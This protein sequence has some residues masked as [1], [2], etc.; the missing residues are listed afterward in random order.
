MLL[1]ILFSDVT[2]RIQP[3]QGKDHRTQYK[4]Q[5]PE[6]FG[7]G[8]LWCRLAYQVDKAGEGAAILLL[9]IAAQVPLCLGISQSF[10]NT[11]RLCFSPG[12]SSTVRAMVSN[13][14]SSGIT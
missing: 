3:R 1:I 6:A 5:A 14:T 9:N 8:K 12:T 13:N 10:P 2:Q 11:L 7:I 4:V